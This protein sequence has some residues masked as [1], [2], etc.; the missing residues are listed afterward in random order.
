MYRKF[1]KLCRKY[2]ELIEDKKFNPTFFCYENELSSTKESIEKVLQVLIK[3]HRERHQLYVAN[4]NGYTLRY[5][6][7]SENIF[8]IKDIARYN[9]KQCIEKEQ[10]IDEEDMFNSWISVN[11]YL[12]MKISKKD[13]LN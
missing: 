7:K 10:C 5:Q 2:N 1:Q 8:K 4:L 6:E 9:I 12:P 13:I 3:R 11:P